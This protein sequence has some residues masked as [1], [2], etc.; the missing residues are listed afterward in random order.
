MGEND[1]VLISGSSGLVGTEL[2]RTLRTRGV[3]V[4][5]LVRR[6]PRN[7]NEVLWRERLEFPEDLQPSAVVHLAGEPVMGIWTA[8]K[9]RRIRDS[10]V[11]RTRELAEALAGRASKP[12]VF[13]SA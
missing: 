11:Q 2:A 1:H 12:R 8:E 13:V 7:D 3:R 5:S 9:K 10:R 4:S 6:N